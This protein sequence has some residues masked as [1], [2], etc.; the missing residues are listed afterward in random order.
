MNIDGVEPPPLYVFRCKCERTM[1][2][3]DVSLTSAAK[4]TLASACGKILETVYI[5]LLLRSTLMDG[6]LRS[7]Y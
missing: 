7:K 5:F 3:I 1:E 6:V 4:F 2:K